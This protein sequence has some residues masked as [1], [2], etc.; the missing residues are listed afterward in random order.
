MLHY[1]IRALKTPSTSDMLISE[2]EKKEE[3]GGENK[4]C[5]DRSDEDFARKTEK[6][7]IL[8]FKEMVSLAFF[9]DKGNSK[10]VKVRS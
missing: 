8:N 2:Y 10:C 7:A 6:T 4:E 9:E 5:F 3:E 1:M